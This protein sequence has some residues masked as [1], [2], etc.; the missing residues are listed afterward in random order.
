VNIG[1]QNI[2]IMLVEVVGMF[3]GKAVYKN[4]YTNQSGVLQLDLSTLKS[5]LYYINLTLDNSK[6]G[7]KIIKR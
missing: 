5:G 6:S 1:N 7:F 2:N 3:D 4:Q